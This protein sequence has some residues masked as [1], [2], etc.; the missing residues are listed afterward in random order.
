MCNNRHDFWDQIDTQ[1]QSFVP[2]IRELI[3]SKFS[4]VCDA[5]QFDGIKKIGESAIEKDGYFRKG[6][7]MLHPF[8]YLNEQ[9][10]LNTVLKNGIVFTA[11]MSDVDLK[12]LN[13]DEN[14]PDIKTEVIRHL[15]IAVFRNHR[16]DI[17]IP[18]T[19]TDLSKEFHCFNDTYEFI[20]VYKARKVSSNG[21]YKL[22]KLLDRYYFN[23]D[24]IIVDNTCKHKKH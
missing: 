11:I 4:Q 17:C 3:R 9:T 5:P 2:Q 15:P 14:L 8:Y 18:G 19:D 23:S 22:I 20:G 1:E 16:G 13:I 21:H 7:Y 12:N 24:K 6:F 10:G